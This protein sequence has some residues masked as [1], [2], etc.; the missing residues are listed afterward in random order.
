MKNDTRKYRAMAVFVVFLMVF[1]SFALVQG[2]SDDS[3]AS[4]DSWTCTI[5]VSGSTITTKYAENGAELSETT[6]VSG[7]NGNA[8]V[9]SWG[10]DDTT[11]YGPFGSYYAA[12]D[13]STGIIYKHLKPSDLSKTIDGDSIDATKYN[14]MWV[15]PTVWM[16]VTEVSGTGNSTLTMSSAEFDGATAPAHTIDG[17]VYNY[18]AIGVYE[19]F[20][21]DSKVY[22]FSGQSPTV[23]TSIANFETHARNTGADGGHSMIWNFYQ[24]QLYRFCS[25]AVMENFDSQAQIGY[26]NASGS[27][28]NTGTTIAKGPYYGTTSASTTGERLFIENAWGNVYDYV[29]DSWWS[30]GLYAGQNSVQNSSSTLVADDNKTT[31]TSGLS[32][33]GTYPYSTN[34]DSWGL[35]TTTGSSGASAPDY[36]YSDSSGNALIVGGNWNSGAIAGLSYLGIG[37]SGGDGSIGSRLAIVFAADPAATPTVTYDHSGLTELLNDGGVAAATLKQK[38]TITEGGTY[39]QLEY[40]GYRHTGW[41]IGEQ[42]VST[43][44]E[45]V[46][47]ESHTAKSVW[48]KIPVVI[49]NHDALTNLGVSSDEISAL[50]STLEIES[51]ATKYPD[52]GTVDGFTHYGWYVDNVFYSP[53]ATVVSTEDHTAYSVWRA[54]SITIT[55]MVEG[56]VHST[57]EVPKG[58]VGIVYT[59]QQVTGV[60]MG[61]Y[62]DESFTQKYDAMK[63]LDSNIELYAKGVM[64]LVFTSVPT[65]DAT[66]TQ[67]D[68]AGLYFF[69]ATDSEGR[70]SV[71]W[72][73]G[74][75]S[76]STDPIAYNSYSEPG[77]YK[78]TLTVTNANGEQAVSHYDVVFGESADGNGS[79]WGLYVI[80]IMLVIVAAVIV[81]RFI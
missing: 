25:L 16:K 39:D 54:P 5:T 68:A 76:T 19:A 52:L 46:S 11:G 79:S 74:D 37:Y 12:F 80:G 75:G 24:Y 45:F 9:G 22:S 6:P 15:L 21:Q 29:G 32:G 60:F 31:V 56:N 58:S 62:Y 64:P 73:F 18:L 8:T 65:A 20:V 14:I 78:V 63:T 40:E 42:E 10:F 23:S 70:Y 50:Q 77:T 55:F 4:S 35:P 53:T 36:I 69:D 33:Y 72:D 71:L 13:I 51:S 1:S 81:L 2:A 27:E 34:L 48:T 17:T 26:G 47:Q 57:L 38:K 43:T 61:W 3:D 49:L 30:K 67:V 44:A 28:T 41:K 66:I 59:P 7:N